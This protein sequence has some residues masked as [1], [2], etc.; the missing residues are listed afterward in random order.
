[1]RWLTGFL[2]L[3]GAGLADGPRAGGAFLVNGDG[4]PLVWD[5]SEPI[6]FNLDQGPLGRLGEEVARRLA[7]ESFGVWE[8]VPTAAVSFVAGEL[9]PCD[10][11]AQTVLACG[12]EGLPIFGRGDDGV[13]PYVFDTD[14]SILDLFFGLGAGNDII[15]IA[16]VAGGTFLPPVASEAEALVNG[17]FFDGVDDAFNPESISSEAFQAVM[18]HENGHWLNLDHSQLNLHVWLDG[19]AGNDRVLPTMFPASTDDDGQLLTLNPDD[20]AT[21]AGLYPLERRRRWRPGGKIRLPGEP[22][23]AHPWRGLGWRPGQPPGGPS[24]PSWLAGAHTR[25]G[26]VQGTVFEPDGVTPFQGAN[27]VLR[28]DRDPEF[29]AYSALSGARF[30][31]APPPGLGLGAFGGPPAP[32]LRGRFDLIGIPPGRYTLEVE[33]VNP[34]FTGASAIGPQALPVFVPGPNEFWNGPRE[35]ADPAR[36]NPG[37]AARVHVGPGKTVT[38]IDIILNRPPP[39]AVLYVVDDELFLLRD[40]LRR[41]TILELDLATGQVLNRI[42]TANSSSRLADGLAHAPSRG[43]LFWTDGLG[44]RSVFEIDPADGTILGELPWPEGTVSIDGLAFLDGPGQPP[45]GV[46]YALDSGIAAIL[47]LDPDTGELLP[48]LSLFF[49]VSLFGGLGGGGDELFVTTFGSLMIQVRPADPAPFVQ[50]LPKPELEQFLLG[51][52]YDGDLV[53]A[54]SIL[55]PEFRIW[56]IDPVPATA[57]GRTGGSIDVIRALPDPTGIVLGGFSA[58]ALARTGDLDGSRQVDGRDLAA[59]ARSF[60]ARDRATR[61]SAGA[62]LDRDGFVGPRDLAILARE[63]GRPARTRRH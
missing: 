50:V 8:A 63:V 7:S 26:H 6:V 49:L 34:L 44:V 54:T 29:L 23:G 25:P 17:R 48:D 40:P 55:P 43:S 39:P 27:L 42:P 16:V 46:L 58:A 5:T 38:G 60:G 9:L 62:D 24:W 13:S 56:Q 15:G 35:S 31:S 14:G 37:E 32:E 18:V 36:D 19:D 10:V 61:Y 59:L 47:A 21:L 12:P 33:E 1:M 11:N 2:L 51:V 41:G 3:L 52:A 22:A 45:G 28:S 30:H 57:R 4:E 53:Y 20:I